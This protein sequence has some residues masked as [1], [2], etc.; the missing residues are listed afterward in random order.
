MTE[1]KQASFNRPQ[2]PLLI[3][4]TGLSGAGKDSVVKRLKKR[5]RPFYFVVT[6]TD[7]PRRPREVEGRDYFFVTTAR[8]EEM[9]ARDEFLENAVVY[10]QNKGVL[11]E[12]ARQAIA[13]GQDVVM[14]LDVQGAATV[15]GHVPAAVTIFLTAESEEE[16]IRR[17]RERGAISDEQLEKRRKTVCEELARIPESDYVVVNRH[18]RLRVTV[19]EVEAII[20]AEHCRSVPQPIIL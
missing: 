3:V 6:V 7:R 19:D 16:L 11:K 4:I 18:D 5:G 2:H 14:R 12:H 15:K 9:I 17:V 8:F 10:G 1:T 20:G 13:S